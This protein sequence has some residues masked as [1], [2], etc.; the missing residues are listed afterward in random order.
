QEFSEI[1]VLKFAACSSTNTP[2]SPLQE[3]RRASF[4]AITWFLF[5]N[6]LRLIALMLKL[7]CWVLTVWAALN[8]MASVKI[9]LET[10]LLNGHTPAL[11]LLLSSADVKSLSPETLA[12]IDSIAI[13]ANGL[14]VA[15]CILALGLVWTGLANKQ[16][17]AFALLLAG[18][19]AAWAAGFLADLAVGLAAPWVNIVS[20]LI[21]G[22][23][24]AAAAIGFAQR[25]SS[26]KRF[27]TEGESPK[28]SC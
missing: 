24:L 3:Q 15:F 25:T 10:L 11:F 14:N 6:A 4:Q 17:A 2:N 5:S 1:G 20:F 12:T 28:A 19:T 22:F 27:G 9:I 8:C 16:S 7:G 23:G 26:S 18:F 13:F 21:L